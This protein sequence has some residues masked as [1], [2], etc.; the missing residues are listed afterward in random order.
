MSSSGREEGR[1]GGK[2]EIRGYLEMCDRLY[3][4][5]AADAAAAVA[6]AE[7][8]GGGEGGGGGGEEEG[9]EQEEEDEDEE[10]DEEEEGE[11]EPFDPMDI[12]M[13][14]IALRVGAYVALPPFRPPGL[15]LILCRPHN[16][17]SLPPSL[18]LSLRHRRQDLFHQERF[19]PGVGV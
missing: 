13:Q 10:E 5:G 2:E 12:V 19:L 16:P 7:I 11:D 9:A 1:E 6:A 15:S 17:P 4:R 3:G 8:G 14:A 18:P